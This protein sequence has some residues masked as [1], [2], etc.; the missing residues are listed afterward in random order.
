MDTK[1]LALIVIFAALSIA[2]EPI[3]I[4]TFFW[5][6][7]YFRL[8]EL[9]VIVAFFLFGFKVGF[10]VSVLNAVGYVAIFPDVSGILGPPWRIILMMSVFTGLILARK[11]KNFTNPQPE[12]RLKKP[13][14]VY[15]IFGIVSRAAIMPFVDIGVYKFL[16]PLVIGRVIPDAYIFGLVPGIV[17]FNILVPLYT[18]PI[19][20][21][22][23]KTIS[24]S[25]KI[26]NLL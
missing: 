10:S 22:A 17:L 23:A 20:Y 25:M 16:L 5:P 8:W 18:I 9:P 11:V 19:A 4:P 6:G 21:G 13:I 1:V 14:V 15:T 3:R 12:K 7:Q 26:G 24:K 2:L